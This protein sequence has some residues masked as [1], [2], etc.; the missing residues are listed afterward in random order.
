M[1]MKSILWMM[2]M[3]FALFTV[4]CSS[5]DTPDED[6]KKDVVTEEQMDAVIAVYVEKVVIPTYKDME[7]KVKALQDAVNVF[8]TSGTQNDLNEACKAWRNARNPWEES[9]AF[10]YGPADD[11]NLDPSLDSWPLDKDGLD[12]LLASGDFGSIGEEDPDND[13]LAEAAQSLRGFHTLEY[14][15]FLDGNPKNAVSV[16]Q[17]EKEYARAVAARLYKDTETLRKG[18][19]DGLG[20]EQVPTA[21]GETLKK[22]NSGTYTSAKSVLGDVIIDGGIINILDEVSGQK[23]GNPYD[24]WKKGQK[25]MAVLEVESWYSWN[26][27]DDY[28]DNIVSV[29]NSYMGERLNRS[30]NV[31]PAS[32][33]SLSTLVRSVDEDL[34]A[35]VQAQIAATRKAI[36]DIPSPFRN[37]LD[38]STE[39]EAAM[40]ACTDLAELFKEVKTALDLF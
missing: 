10:L 28:E 34:D 24:Y 6:D 12:Q 14:L 1:K 30:T 5:D 4:A 17:N 26:S 7:T 37:H 18:W 3:S 9:E 39:I 11:E 22:H 31:R 29:E 15:L 38:A 40:D 36:R 2:L 32:R 23:I 13:D 20:T 16:S 25:E 8:Y 33:A 19:T 21:F 27:L 35:R